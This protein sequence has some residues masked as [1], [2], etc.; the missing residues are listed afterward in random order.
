[1]QRVFGL[2][3]LLWV[4]SSSVLAQP[5]S[6]HGFGTAF[7]VSDVGHLITSFHVVRDA[8]TVFVRVPSASRRFEAEV[9]SVDEGNDLALLKVAAPTRP[10]TIVEYADVPIG[11]EVFSLGFPQPSVQGSSLKITSGILN[12]REGLKGDSGSFQFSAPIQR[13]NS[14]GP[15]LLLD[16]GVIGL[17]QGKLGAVNSGVGQLTDVPQNVNFATNAQRLKEFLSSKAVP[18]SYR[19]ARISETL[20][21]HQIYDQA[22]ESIFAVEITRATEVENRIKESLVVPPAIAYYLKELDRGEQSRLLGA[23]GIGFNRL[24]RSGKT[25]LL[26]RSSSDGDVTRSSE[27]LASISSRLSVNEKLV[28]FILTL[29]GFRTYPSKGFAY[30]SVIMTVGLDCQRIQLRTILKEYKEHSFGGGKTLLKLLRKLNAGDKAEHIRM[31][32][33]LRHFVKTEFCLNG[34]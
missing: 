1:M 13:G 30:K 9:L 12:S 15:V 11:I 19:G 28:E 16:G 14:G 23:L 24:Y 6:P 34:S 7:A 27:R 29:E 5:A 22:I 26:F 10:L 20:R 21:P 32:D 4:L 2:F 25:L 33:E 31:S 17:I 18:I 8:K 3:S